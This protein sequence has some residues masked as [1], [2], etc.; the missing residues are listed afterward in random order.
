GFTSV[1]SKTQDQLCITVFLE[2]KKKPVPSAPAPPQ[3]RHFGAQRKYRRSS[4]QSA[5]AGGRALDGRTLGA[6]ARA[7]RQLG[8]DLQGISYGCPLS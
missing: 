2:R 8:Y 3:G 6:L 4:V 7:G 1:Y 5:S